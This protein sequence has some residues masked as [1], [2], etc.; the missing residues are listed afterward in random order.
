MSKDCVVLHSSQKRSRR[1]SSLRPGLWVLGFLVGGGALVLAT[2]G[3]QA[4]PDIEVTQ[5]A[6]SLTPPTP[7]PNDINLAPYHYENTSRVVPPGPNCANG[8]V[9]LQT[10]QSGNPPHLPSHLAASHLL[11]DPTNNHF[12]VT[13]PPTTF[14]LDSVTPDKSLFATDNQMVRL[15]DGSLLLV[16]AGFTWA[17]TPTTSYSNT[18]IKFSTD[19]SAAP[20]NGLRGAFGLFKST[21][22]GNSWALWQLIDFATLDGGKFGFPVPSSAGGFQSDGPDRPEMYVDPFNGNVY[23]T[24]Q[25]QAG[26]FMGQPAGSNTLLEAVLIMSSDPDHNVWNVVTESLPTVE[27]IV[28]TSTPSGRLF[29]LDDENG[30]PMMRFSTA[31]L[32]S[33]QP[34][35]FSN[36]FPASFQTNGSPDAYAVAKAAGPQAGFAIRLDQNTNWALYAGTAT[37]GTA[38]TVN[39]VCMSNG[40][41]PVSDAG[42]LWTYQNGMIVSARNPTMAVK[43]SSGAVQGGAITLTSS[44]TPSDSNCTWTYEKGLFES[45]SNQAFKINAFGAIDGNVVELDSTCSPSVLTCTWTLPHVMFSNASNKGLHMNAFGGARDGGVVAVDNACTASNTDCLWTLSAGMIF[46]ETNRLL[47]VNAFGGAVSGNPIELISF[48]SA[49]NP[50]CTWKLTKGELQSDNTSHGLVGIN[51]NGP[52]ASGT[53]LKVDSAC[54]TSTATCLYSGLGMPADSVDIDSATFITPSLSRVSTDTSSDIVRLV[55]QTMNTQGTQEARIVQFDSASPNSPTSV[56]AIQADSPADHHVMY[57]SFIDPDA[58][59][60]PSLFD[61]LNTSMLYWYEMPSPSSVTHDYGTRF[62][63]VSGTTASNK[64]FLSVS[65]GAPRTWSV[66]ADQGDYV[67]SGFFW[68]NKTFN[69]VPQW[70]ENGGINYNV[71]TVPSATRGFMIRSDRNSGLF[72]NAFDGAAEG[73]VLKLS[74]SCAVTNPDCTWSYANGMLVSDTNPGLAIIALGAQEGT[75]LKLTA[76]CTPANTDCTWTYKNGEFFSDTNAALAINAWDGAVDGATLVTTAF[77]SSGNP[78]CTWTLPNVLLTTPGNRNLAVNAFGGAQNLTTLQLNSFC[79]RS[80]TDCTWSFTHGEI[81]SDTNLGLAVNA[82]QGAKQGTTLKLINFCSPTNPDC[83]FT[84]QKGEIISDNKTNGTL[85][86]LATSG[87]VAGSTLTLNTGCTPTN[88]NCQ[89]EGLYGR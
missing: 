51:L 86:V 65:N 76:A 26:P 83:T 58:M 33:G 39:S 70:T 54:T 43:A 72:V 59:D 27:P 75:V 2:C 50:D 67:S 64:G 21:D 14:D 19:L 16:R 41:N 28:M 85:P 68:R 57:A 17:T 88:P 63:M 48:C 55:Y 61:P 18:P 37:E 13:S 35:T 62:L 31:P 6:L 79:S 49:T 84:W 81:L 69:Y 24:F 29:L 46:S 25:A 1:D 56:A 80:N 36:A 82:F 15:K 45:D 7:L 52:V 71:V 73:T 23:I 87:A 77:C 47:A 11:F 42:C 12:D 20:A 32:V 66:R 78:D 9:A 74:A 22:C 8:R 10:G 30:A 38:V 34:G 5:A 60:Q 89:W 4:G 53:P 44:C 3:Y 40:S